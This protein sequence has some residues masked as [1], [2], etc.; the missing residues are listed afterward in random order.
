MY[1][2]RF[3][4]EPFPEMNVSLAEMNVSYNLEDGAFMYDTVWAAVLA[5]DRTAEMGYSLTDFNYLNESFSRVIYNEALKV[6][7]FGLTVS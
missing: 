6:E 4:N 2:Q 5:L 3:Y 7:F 1:D